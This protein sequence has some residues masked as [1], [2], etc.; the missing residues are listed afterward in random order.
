MAGPLAPFVR[1]LHAA[2]N[3][4]V[5]DALRIGLSLQPS[6]ALVMIALDRGFF[7]DQGLK[8]SVE[9][10][11]SGVRA[12]R[13][14][15][16]AGNVDLVTASDVPVA[17]NSFERQDFSIVATI[18]RVENQNRIVARADRGIAKPADLTGKRIATQRGSAV[19]FFLHLFLLE[20]GILES[21]VDQTFM[22][23]GELPEAL[24]RGDI[25]AFSMREPY[26]GQARALLGG[27]A[28]DVLR[29]KPD[30]AKKILR[31]LVKAENFVAGKPKE[32][33]A[34]VARFVGASEAEIA[35]IWP[36]FI[37]RVSL[38]QS[39]LLRLEDIGRWAVRRQLVNGR[40]TPNFLDLIYFEAMQTVKPVAI[41]VVR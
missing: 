16:F 4:P 19:H 9:K 38:E 35:A 25:D 40:Q 10:Y 7:A 8:V 28:N 29:E 27:N 18:F 12:L 31:A 22:K 14:G 39:L 21:D 20:N 41:T 34:I 2:K 5:E 37:P 11:V 36:E 33:Q 23:A 24:A 1:H 15:L 6:N 13:D 17:L 30:I 3:S 32:S 26:I